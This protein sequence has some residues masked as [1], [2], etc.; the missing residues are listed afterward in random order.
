MAF[1]TVLLI[2]TIKVV[3]E[4]RQNR[5]PKHE[6]L[7]MCWIVALMQKKEAVHTLAL[8][9]ENIKILEDRVATILHPELVRY[10]HKAF[11]QGEDTSTRLGR[12]KMDILQV[13][14]SLVIPTTQ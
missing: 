14:D 12:F 2:R 7:A 5:C 1:V 3:F 13:L 11:Y 9:L 6:E 8:T 10:Y 4:R